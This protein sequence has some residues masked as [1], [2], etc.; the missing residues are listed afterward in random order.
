MSDFKTNLVKNI[1]REDIAE[2]YDGQSVILF[3]LLQFFIQDDLILLFVM[4]TA[5]LGIMHYKRQKFLT[6]VFPL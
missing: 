4:P 1:I 2:L 5:P 3:F 6:V